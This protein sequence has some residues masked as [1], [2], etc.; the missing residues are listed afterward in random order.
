MNGKWCGAVGA[1][2][3]C[4]LG[5]RI[6]RR[7]LRSCAVYWLALAVSFGCWAEVDAEPGG[8]PQRI[9]W[10]PDLGGHET[11]LAVML[12]AAEQK[13]IIDQVEQTSFDIPGDWQLELRVRRVSLGG[14]EGLVV[15]GTR[16]LCGGT[17]NCQTWVF[18]LLQG[19][20]FNLFEREAPIVSGFGFEQGTNLSIQNL[21]VSSNNSARKERR[22]LFKFDGKYYRQSDCYD[23]LFN[24]PGSEKVVKV[25]CT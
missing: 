23:V 4:A 10:L 24:A 3:R 13:Q 15:R 22:I 14:A 25:P 8:A 7:V 11:F 21:L 12:T 19:A 1:R 17:G 16:L 20:W 6:G 2:R 9:S 5:V 18:R